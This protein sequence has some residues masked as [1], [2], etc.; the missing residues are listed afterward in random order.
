MRGWAGR[1]WTLRLRGIHDVCARLH[2]PW[3]GNPGIVYHLQ[4]LSFYLRLSAPRRWRMWERTGRHA[5]AW[6]AF[7]ALS[8]FYIIPVTAVQSLLAINSVT[9]WLASVP[10]RAA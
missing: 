2:S 9:G 3:V 1:G 10:V 7:V 4:G 6:A 8:L 5:L